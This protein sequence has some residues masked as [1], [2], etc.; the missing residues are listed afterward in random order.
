VT[1]DN[2]YEMIPSNAILSGASGAYAFFVAN[3]EPILSVA[4]PFGLFI[5]GK[6]I[7]VGIKLY[8]HKKQNK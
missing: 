4:I 6:A 1:Y 7:D 5:L 3:I 8:M 2:D